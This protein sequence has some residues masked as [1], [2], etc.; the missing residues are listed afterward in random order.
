MKITPCASI[1][2]KTDE[3]KYPDQAILTAY[4]KCKKINDM[5]CFC[6]L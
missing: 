2:L 5:G 4:F 1:A 6:C 3:A